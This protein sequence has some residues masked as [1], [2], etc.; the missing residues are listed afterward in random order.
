MKAINSA[1]L[2]TLSL[3]LFVVS[4][5]WC[6]PTHKSVDEEI[7]DPIEPVNRGIF[8]FNDRADRYAIDP[9]ARGYEKAIPGRV[10]TGIGN[11]FDN[12]RFP[13]IF[14]SDIVQG[15]FT[16]AL[17]A[18]GRFL[19]NST[20]G[21][22]GVMDVA[23]DVGLEEQDQDFGLALASH[24]VPPGP[25][26][27]LPFLGASNVRDAFGRVV[28]TVISPFYHLGTIF[29]LNDNDALAIALGS[30]ALDVLNQRADLLEAVKAA[31]E[32]S[33]DYYL[34]MQTAYYQ[35]RHGMLGLAE[36]ESTT[37]ED[38]LADPLQQ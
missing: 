1:L 24:D 29:D 22:A 8:W 38:P 36:G 14:L 31:R 9:L 37:A 2:V 17:E 21:I 15:E 6:E 10:R 3:A 34:F 4:P 12:L 28:D 23:V 27:V 16:N 13:A 33:L 30:R 35:H 25:Y 18:T 5:A 11:F 26:L 20:V 7:W 32:S 19:I